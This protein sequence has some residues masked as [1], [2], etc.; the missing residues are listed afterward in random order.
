VSRR[1]VAFAALADARKVGRPPG[2]RARVG[3]HSVPQPRFSVDYTPVVRL[4]DEERLRNR[5]SPCTAAPTAKSPARVRRG[6]RI[7]S[8][9]QGNTVV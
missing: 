2:A 4:S 3:V 9:S 1:A 7:R 5:S 8:D 6:K